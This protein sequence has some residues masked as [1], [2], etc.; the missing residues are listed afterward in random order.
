METRRHAR[1]R[2]SWRAQIATATG[3]VE[4][5]VVDVAE[6]G[7]GMLCDQAFPKGAV[8]DLVIGVPDLVDR[9]RVQPVGLQVQI[10]FS[11]FG[12]HQCRLGV[13]FT[14]IGVDAQTLIKWH[15]NRG[16]PV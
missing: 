5:R 6:L 16:T 10:M 12:G 9:T 2:A 13:Q 15:V 4:A 14:R 8:L 11:H 3:P 7:M 1:V